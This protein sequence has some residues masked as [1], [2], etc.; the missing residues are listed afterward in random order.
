MNHLQYFL[1]ESLMFL[2]Q[3]EPQSFTLESFILCKR[4]NTIKVRLNRKNINKKFGYNIK[5]Y[6]IFARL[7]DIIKIVKFVI[8]YTNQFKNIWDIKRANLSE[9]E[10]LLPTEPYP[11]KGMGYFLIK[12]VIYLTICCLSH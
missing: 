3:L 9:C 4:V 5:F 1:T 12:E 6:Y 11:F 8:I 7:F 10:I 2:W